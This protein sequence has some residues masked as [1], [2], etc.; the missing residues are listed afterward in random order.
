MKVTLNRHPTYVPLQLLE[1]NYLNP[2]CRLDRTVADVT[3]FFWL[4]VEE[5]LL[6]HMLLNA[7]I[8]A[9]S[10]MQLFNTS[11]DTFSV[12]KCHV[13]K[14]NDPFHKTDSKRLLQIKM[15]FDSFKNKQ[16]WKMTIKANFFLIVQ[17]GNNL[18]TSWS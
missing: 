11:C 13:E 9:S 5:L 3:A 18:N 16:S 2:C 12:I 8:W 4:L 14:F 17:R 10:N 6:A 15:Q 7:K 1:K